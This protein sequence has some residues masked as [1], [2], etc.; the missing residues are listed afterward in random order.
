MHNSLLLISVAENKAYSQPTVNNSD[1]SPSFAF[2]PCVTHP[3]PKGD[4]FF[5]FFG[6]CWSLP[7]TLCKKKNACVLHVKCSIYKLRDCYIL[8][9]YL[10]ILTVGLE[11]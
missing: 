4:L 11:H 2:I 1:S 3:G 8:S 7:A 6:R 5:F 9:V 10:Q